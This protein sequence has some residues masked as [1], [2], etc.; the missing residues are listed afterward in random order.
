M[1]FLSN[2]QI[3]STITFLAGICLSSSYWV[4]SWYDYEHRVVYNTYEI[5]KESG[6]SSSSIQKLKSHFSELS[7]DAKLKFLRSPVHRRTREPILFD[8]YFNANLRNEFG[9]DYSKYIHI[10]DEKEM[11][12]LMY[13]LQVIRTT[14]YVKELIELGADP[15]ESDAYDKSILGGFPIKIVI[16]TNGQQFETVFKNVSLNLVIKISYCFCW[17]IQQMLINTFYFPKTKIFN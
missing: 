17:K 12:L 5:V 2:A 1:G 13:S 9:L 10:K 16:D 14:Q 7:E 8:I 11:S 15:N 4:Y 3:T 6:Y